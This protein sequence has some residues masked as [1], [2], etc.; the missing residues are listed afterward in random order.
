MTP[1]IGTARHIAVRRC[2]STSTAFRATPTHAANSVGVTPLHQTTALTFRG[3]I[4]VHKE[5]A[6]IEAIAEIGAAIQGRG[7]RVRTPSCRRQTMRHGVRPH[8]LARYRMLHRTAAVT[9]P[10]RGDQ[11]PQAL[12]GAG[13]GD[14]ARNAGTYGQASLP[15]PPVVMPQR[16]AG[17]PQ[18]SRQVPAQPQARQQPQAQRN[19]PPPVQQATPAPQL[20]QRQAPATPSAPRERERS[21]GEP[22]N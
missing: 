22:I 11:S 6:V 19:V 14:A 16:P 21:R 8:C 13:R 18:P 5:V 7:S 10:R 1:T 17:N 9:K 15:R 12:E 20:E 3:M 2:T 4:V